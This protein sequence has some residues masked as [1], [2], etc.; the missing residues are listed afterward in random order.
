MTFPN[1]YTLSRNL[2]NES[3]NE[4][5]TIGISK[6]KITQLDSIQFSY[7]NTLYEYDYYK[8]LHRNIRDNFI[9]I[10]FYRFVDMSINLLSLLERY[11]CDLVERINDIGNRFTLDECSNIV[12]GE[13][14]NI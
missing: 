6:G 5:L 2:Y 11:N 8:E 7:K 9:K 3:F 1:L 12:V 13:Y 4:M 10:I 14:S